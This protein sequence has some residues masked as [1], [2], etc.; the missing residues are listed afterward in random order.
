MES[1]EMALRTN[2]LC[3]LQGQAE[4]LFD[5]Y[6]PDTLNEV[7]CKLPDCPLT[8]DQVNGLDTTLSTQLNMTAFHGMDV[9]TAVWIQA[10]VW[11]RDLF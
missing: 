10:L 1:T 4:N 11:C 6:A 3:E 2:N 7:P 8:L 9:Y 5:G